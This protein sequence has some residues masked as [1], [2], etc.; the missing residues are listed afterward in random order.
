VR[1]STARRARARHLRA[2][3]RRPRAHAL[4]DEIREAFMVRASSRASRPRSRRSR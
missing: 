3:P 1:R 4:S 2:E